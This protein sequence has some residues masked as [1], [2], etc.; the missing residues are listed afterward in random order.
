[1]KLISLLFILFGLNKGYAQV[2][3]VPLPASMQLGKGTYI[4]KSPLKILYSNTL[5]KGHG[6][7]EIFK[8]HLLKEYGIKSIENDNSHNVNN[9]TTIY[10][11]VVNSDTTNQ[12]ELSVNKKGIL[13]KGNANG[14]FYAFET[15]K[16]ILG[17]TKTGQL[18]V[19]HLL[20]KDIPRFAYRGMHLD[21][22]RHFFTIPQVKKYIDYLATY[23]YNTFH[24]HLTDDQGWRIEIKQYPNL[25]TKGAYRDRTLIG[26]F[27]SNIYD[28]IPYG[29]FYTQA[30]IKEIVQYA[31]ERYIQVIPEI[32]MPGHSLAAL[33]SYPY[34]GCT[35]GEYKVMDTWG[36]FDDVLCAG[37]DSTFTFLQNVLAEIMPLFTSQ[38][39]HIG[40]DECPKKRWEDCNKCQDRMKTYNLK[41]EH[42]L[43]SYF[44]QRI[45][46]YV[47]SQGKSII[48]WDEILEGGLAPN[49]T[50]MSWRGE[51]GG[52][53]AAK[54]AHHVIMTPGSHCYLDH[55]Q[56]MQEDSVTIGNYLP[57]EKLY[58]YEPIPTVLTATQA[59]C[60]IGAQ[61]NVWTEYIAN[62]SKLEYMIFPRM[63]ALSEVLWTP[64]DKRNWESFKARLPNVFER[65]SHENINY[66]KAYYELKA[67]ILPSKNFDGVYLQLQNNEPTSDIRYIS[68]A[69][70][71]KSN[72]YTKP[73][74]LKAINYQIT[75]WVN[76]L[77]SEA[78]TK[79][80]KQDIFINKATGKKITL[81]VPPS[82]RYPGEG[83]FTL[84]N[85]IH[86]TSGLAKRVEMLG[87]AG[88]DVEAIID[89]KNITSINEVKLHLFI[90]KD[91]WIYAPKADKITVLISDDG[92]NF[93]TPAQNTHIALQANQAVATT[94]F[95]QPN[96]NIKARYIKITAKNFGKIPEGMPGQGSLSWLFV[97]EIGVN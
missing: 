42:A 83:A 56:S 49:A 89:L 68:A 26:R 31:T 79:P 67:S 45:E 7:V 63:I 39:I 46:K 35:K 47:N 5:T 57:V 50:V 90:K 62:Q 27:G 18:E 4:L 88:T 95:T 71:S 73:I 28:T 54:Q 66:S 80:I 61:G 12:Y 70:D 55:S 48:G 38:Y 93:F 36:V 84:V 6:G 85:G 40:G 44:I 75:A 53:E 24:W 92:I 86:N 81:A 96:A 15:L 8:A 76:A 21:V 33:A 94:L 2:N 65:L 23:K 34:L 25:T 13:I 77:P 17:K 29:G 97:H 60:I 32:E 69:D 72:Y 59:K 19:P 16:Q 64:K 87:F 74:L 82:E 52:I 14:I 41:D 22:S 1:M 3:I 43:Q 9:A 37:N 51:A 58:N 20:I 78:K 91:S 30:E 11:T 10:I